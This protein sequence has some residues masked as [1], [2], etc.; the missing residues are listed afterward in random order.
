MTFPG[1]LNRQLL[2]QSHAPVKINV[3][4][5]LI[6]KERRC[7]RQGLVPCRWRITEFGCAGADCNMGSRTSQFPHPGEKIIKP[8]PLVGLYLRGWCR[9]RRLNV[10]PLDKVATIRGAIRILV[11][12]TPQKIKGLRRAN[13]SLDERFLVRISAGLSLP[14][15]WAKLMTPEA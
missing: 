13:H 4:L 8:N 7:D 10:T 1:E 5:L 15:M 2:A 6:D 9:C 14:S 12:G 3:L 11:I